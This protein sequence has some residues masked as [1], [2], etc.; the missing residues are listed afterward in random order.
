MIYSMTQPASDKD[1]CAIDNG[2][3]QHVCK[4]TIGSYV[5]SCSN[6]FTLHENGHDCK[7]GGCKHEITSPV[8]EIFSPNY[9]DYYP[10]RKDC[11]WQFT[12]TPGHRIK[13]VTCLVVL[14]LCLPHSR[15]CTP[16]NTNVSRHLKQNGT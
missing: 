7:E 5:C 13:L 16:S 9:P 11:V 10:S 15:T 4:N 1:E 3:C 14:D 8:G 2:G 12:T 6:G